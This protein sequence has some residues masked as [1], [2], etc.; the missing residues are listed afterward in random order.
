MNT[1]RLLRRRLACVVRVE[2]A[3]AWRSSL[4][5]LT[6]DIICG[7]LLLV[8]VRGRRAKVRWLGLARMLVGRVQIRRRA[9]S[10]GAHVAQLRLAAERRRLLLLLLQWRSPI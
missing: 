2:L 1:L 10:E 6:I 8:V 3:Q 4:W 7:L 9:V 5:L